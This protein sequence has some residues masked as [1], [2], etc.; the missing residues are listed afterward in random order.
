MIIYD[1][2]LDE[3]ILNYVPSM[4]HIIRGF[5]RIDPSPIQY[6]SPIPEPTAP[7]CFKKQQVQ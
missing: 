3:T 6:N 5:L 2:M 7:L 4:L 1:Y